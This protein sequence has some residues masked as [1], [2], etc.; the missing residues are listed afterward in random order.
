VVENRGVHQRN[1]IAV[2]FNPY[3]RMES[4]DAA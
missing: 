3:I 2:T 4:Y 1:G